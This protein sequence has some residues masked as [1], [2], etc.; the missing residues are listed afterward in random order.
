MKTKALIIGAGPCGMSAAFGLSSKGLDAV[1][2][3]KNSYIGGLASTLS[4][5]G[6]KT[7]IG[8][9]RFFSK[10]KY[11]YDMI[12]DL[13]KQDWI[14]VD[15]LTR[16]YIREKFFMYPVDIADTLK[17]LGF[18][19]SFS[20]MR[21]YSIQKIKNSFS[22]PEIK[23]FEDKIVSDFGRAL[24]E[25]NMLN[26]TEKIW[27]LPC[28][29]ISP[30]WATQRIKDL[31]LLEVLKKAL[32][33]GGSKA[34]TLVDA[35]YYPKF[36]TKTI[37]EAMAERAQKA[38]IMTETV[39]IEIKHENGVIKSVI[40][41][42]K[43]GKTEIE[44]ESY[45]STMPLTELVKLFSPALDP[46]ILNAASA[47][48][49]RSHVSLFAAIDTDSVFKDQW[50][51]LPDSYIPFGRIMEPKNFSKDLCEE[52]KTSLLLEF[53]CWFGDD[54][55]SSSADRLKN[56]SVPWLEKIFK[57]KE[58]KIMFCEVHK[59]KFAYPVYD[60]GYK[61]NLDSVKNALSQ[62]SNLQPAGRGGAF[63]YNNQD[64]AMEMGLLAAANIAEGVK[65]HNI[66]DI[67]SEQAYFEKGYVK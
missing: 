10:N 53:F 40:V 22:K 21:D 28:S 8:P 26:Y 7:D 9:H 23:S 37:Y 61:E 34:K 33:L 49:Y 36:G 60:L 65:K 56:I 16:F 13:L 55:W 46:K 24:A 27:G 12:E 31:S 54:I 45:I 64:H 25:L 67:G 14:R 3:E 5:G 66:D 58:D 17:N 32:N 50:I 35:F 38:K 20:V 30:D 39:P 52:G 63:K 11:L 15:R 62:F 47:L 29:Q 6:Y 41:E 2:V 19:G 18:I 43:D 1:V 57:I 44:A 4:F 42:N 51:Y 59:E 48:K